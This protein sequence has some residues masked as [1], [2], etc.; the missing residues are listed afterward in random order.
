MSTNTKITK[1]TNLFSDL[2][3]N[4]ICKNVVLEY[5]SKYDYYSIDIRQLKDYFGGF[6]QKLE[7]LYTLIGGKKYYF[8]NV[9]V[10]KRESTIVTNA[11]IQVIFE[12]S[13]DTYFYNDIAIDGVFKDINIEHVKN[14][15]VDFYK[16][17]LDYISSNNIAANSFLNGTYIETDDKPMY[18][19]SIML[20]R[21]EGSLELDV[22][23][24]YQVADENSI[25]FLRN[26]L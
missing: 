15:F 12:K 14:K 2:D 22:F 11:D 25:L 19:S 26:R 16:I 9:F 3:H 8:S 17:A 10:K 1:M 18:F 4:V 6:M 5:N 7:L 24:T 23:V 20:K 13:R 21:R